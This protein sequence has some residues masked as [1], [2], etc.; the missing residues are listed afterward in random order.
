MIVIVVI[1]VT[2]SSSS[3]SCIMVKWLADDCHNSVEAVVLK[4]HYW[5]SCDF[6]HQ[7]D[8]E[9]KIVDDT[10]LQSTT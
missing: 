7:D 10:P 3:N 9:M 1:V 2:S 8:D 4:S 6:H 5:L